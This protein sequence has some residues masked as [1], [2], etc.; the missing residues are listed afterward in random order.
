TRV[1]SA[2]D[3]AGH[4]R[5]RVV[6]NGR[7]YDHEIVNHGRRRSHVILAWNVARD[8]AQAHLAS[9]AEVRTRIASGAVERDEPRIQRGFETAAPT[10]TVGFS[11]FLSGGHGLEPSCDATIDQPVTVIPV[12]LGF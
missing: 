3:S 2:D 5:P 4:F 8:I 12:K 7:A 11:G 1:K 9:L 10:G 6:V